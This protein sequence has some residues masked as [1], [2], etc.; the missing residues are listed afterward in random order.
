[1]RG[2][3]ERLQEIFLAK[4]PAKS[5]YRN[6]KQ[7]SRQEILNR[8]IQTLNPNEI[9]LEFCLFFSF[10]I[11]SNFGSFDLGSGQVSSFEFVAM[12]RAL[13]PFGVPQSLP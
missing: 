10:E 3:A 4:Q 7:T 2:L 12:W 5:E 13:R 9:C 8:K 11:V 1:L 6:P